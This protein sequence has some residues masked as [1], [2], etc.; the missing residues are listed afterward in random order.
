VPQ[1]NKTTPPKNGPL[2]RG[3]PKKA[4]V[5]ERIAP[6]E[7]SA[8]DP[9]QLL[10]YGRSG[11][12][13]TTIWSTFPKPILGVICSGGTKNPGELRSI[14]KPGAG[15]HTKQVRLRESSELREIIDAV[16]KGDIDY[17]TVA[18]D[19][20]SGFQDLLLKEQLGLDG[21]PVQKT[22]GLASRE[23]YGTIGIKFKEYVTALLDLPANVVI[24]AH[25]RGFNNEGESEV[26][27]PFI[28]AALT[29]GLSGWLNGTVDYIGQCFLRNKEVEKMTVVGGKK[30]PIKMKTKEVE[31]C[32]RVGP[33]PT[34]A[35]KF[36][37]PDPRRVPTVVVNPTYDKL[38]GLI[39]ASQGE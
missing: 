4:G 14:A 28:G 22:W 16:R 27:Q 34:Y 11:T 7:F 20:A 35:T 33:D 38:I 6:V 5:L 10:L 18:L 8:D 15:K 1:I 25:E 37:V 29:P 23:A 17:K 39:R 9:I 19:H 3:L 13:K 12:G 36:R 21:I 24:V 32:L 30:K 31:Y 2:Q 26:M